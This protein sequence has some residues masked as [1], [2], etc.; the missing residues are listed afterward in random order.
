[1]T[2]PIIS[3]GILTGDKVNFDLYGEFSS[4][5][6]PKKLSGKLNA[7]IREGK[8][9][10][11]KDGIELCSDEK[12][13]ITPADFETDSFLLHDVKIGKSFHWEKIEDQRFRGSLRL[14]IEEGKVTAVNIIPL[15]EYLTSVISSEM[16]AG[17]SLELL[18][19]HAVVSRGW[20]IAQLDKKKEQTASAREHVFI[21]NENELVKW[22]DRTEHSLYDFCSDD[23][24]QRYQGV[25][26]IISDTVFAAVE[27]TRGMVLTYNGKVCDT[28]FSKCCGGITES[29]ENVWAPVNYPYLSSVIDYKFEPGGYFVDLT[30]ESYAVKWIKG[31]PHAF[32]NTED[33]KILSQILVD[34]DQTTKDFYRWKVEYKQDEISEII[35]KRSGIDFGN[36]VD[37]I[38]LERG[39]SGRI[40]KLKIVGTKKE[41]KV[42]KELEIRK[43]LSNSHLYSSAFV[44]TKGKL[45]KGIPQKFTLEGAG[46]GHGVGLCQIGAAVMGEMGY[47][48]D[49]I[50]SHYFKRSRLEKIY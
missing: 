22:Y 32:C 36:I 39:Y 4:P 44:V 8:I 2:E 19:A 35:F 25:T 12:I 3:V 43:W 21:K 38:P 1:M 11:I 30:K 49:E 5:I 6:Y 20:L 10:L 18:K 42:G 50:L 26:R 29:F 37:L 46:W 7:V 40:S 13:V 28:R 17:S 14:I 31:A 45:Q 9:I 24:C 15:E 23:H 47:S 48:F 33:P 41:F 34:Y 27:E 16:S